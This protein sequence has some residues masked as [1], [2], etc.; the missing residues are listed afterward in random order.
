MP[1][2]SVIIPTHNRGKQIQW[3]IASVLAQSYA[4][5]EAIVVDDGTEDD[6][7]RIVEACAPEDGQIRLIQHHKQKGAQ[8]ARNTEFSLPPGNG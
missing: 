7:V 5:L 2:I 8:A 6:T 3:A 1:R 4:D